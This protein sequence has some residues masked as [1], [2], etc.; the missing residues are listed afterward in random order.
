MENV[1]S[2]SQTGLKPICCLWSNEETASLGDKIIH[3]FQHGAGFLH[4]IKQ[5]LGQLKSTMPAHT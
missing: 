4:I 2:K 5:D 1:H 3:C